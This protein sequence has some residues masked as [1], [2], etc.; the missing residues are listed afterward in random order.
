MQFLQ[1]DTIAKN[2][3]LIILHTDTIAKMKK[4]KGLTEVEQ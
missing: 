4:A 2:V 3:M 1:T